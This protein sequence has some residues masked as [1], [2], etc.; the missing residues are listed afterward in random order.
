MQ[1]RG[2]GRD[3]ESRVKILRNLAGIKEEPKKKPEKEKK[4]K[5]KDAG[6]PEGKTRK[7][8]GRSCGSDFSV[9]GCE[10]SA[11]QREACGWR[12]GYICGKRERQAGKKAWG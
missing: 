3:P 6:A 12:G 5:G 2:R 8:E 7:I 1:L 9:S 4:R 10:I 11:G